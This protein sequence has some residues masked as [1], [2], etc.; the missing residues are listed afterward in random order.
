M[1]AIVTGASRGIG[2]ELTR[3]L[4]ARGD[5]ALAACRSPESAT[6]LAALAPAH[7]DRLHVHACDIGDG[8][9]VAAFAAELGDAAIDLLVNNAG[10]WGG[11]HQSLGDLDV[12]E[13]LRTYEVNALGALRVTLAVLPHLRRGQGKKIVHVTSGLGSILDNTSGGYY[14]YR[15]AKAALNMASRSLAVDLRAERITSVVIDPGWVRTDMGGPGASLTAEA[16]V[17]GMLREID[18][19]TLE[20]S[21]AFLRWRGGDFPF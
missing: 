3:Q 10:V 17:Q 9:S 8:K 1:R 11:E 18:A 12:D 20:R 15:M 19:V 14:G 13:A 21:G 5:T 7:P 4:L 2:L 6:A 16:S